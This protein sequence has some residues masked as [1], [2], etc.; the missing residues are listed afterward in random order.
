MDGVRIDKWLWC[1]RL[2]KSRTLATTACEAGKVKIDG[3]PAKP[4][5]NIKIGDVIVLPVGGVARTVKVRQ[6]LQ[7]RVGAPKVPEFMEDL[8]APEE[9][10][11]AREEGARA[12]GLRPKGSGRPTKRDR[13]IL[14]SFFD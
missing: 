14:Q 5:R 7:Q 4:S 6:L 8:T 10:Q 12:S 13:R 11:K 1:V 3:Q 9:F 2:F